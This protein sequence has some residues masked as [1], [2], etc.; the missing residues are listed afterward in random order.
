M[1]NPFSL[2]GKTILVTGAS[3]GIGRATAIACAQMGATVVVTGRDKQRLNETFNTLEGEGHIQISANLADDNQIEALVEQLP[4]L[5]GLVNNAGITETC[6]TQFIKRDKLEK[7]MNVNTFAPILLTQKILKKKKI[8]TGGSIVFTCSIS[9]TT[10]CGGGNVLYSASKGAIHGFM[11]NAALD[12]ASKGIRVNDVC[13][14][15]IDTHILDAGIIGEEE[16]KIEAQKYPMKRFGMPE[17]VAYGIIYL[18]SDAS[19][20][21]TGSSI[22]IDGGFTLQ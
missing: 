17:E 15:M 10:V 6:P 14:G 13:P 22:I 5:H 7:V 1:I 20:F 9:G 2:E 8:G 4:I 19:S 3:S 11:R 16:L 21:C 18:L 12:L